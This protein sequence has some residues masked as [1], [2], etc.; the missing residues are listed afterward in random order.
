[1]ASFVLKIKGAFEKGATKPG[2]GAFP[3]RRNQVLNQVDQEAITWTLDAQG[4]CSQLPSVQNV[5]NIP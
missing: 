3:L 1:M 2:M 4:Q 5:S